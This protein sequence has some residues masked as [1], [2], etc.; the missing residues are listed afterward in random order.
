[1]AMWTFWLIASVLV[2]VIEL[3][4]GVVYLLVLSLAFLGAALSAFL[5]HFEM[6]GTLL[7]A[8]IMSAIGIVLVYQFR[9]NASKDSD[10][11]DLDIGNI[12]QIEQSLSGG[13]WRVFYR[14]TT[15]EAQA[16]QAYY[17]FEA[18]EHARICAKNGITLIIEPLNH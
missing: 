10:N 15:W 2:F 4:L 16:E 18:G 17:L 14:G 5:F 8:S 3:F 12:V 6:I 11:N 7:I 9:K 1:M 13:V